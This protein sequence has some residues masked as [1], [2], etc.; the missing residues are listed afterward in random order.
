MH[1]NSEGHMRQMLI[2]GE[3]AGKHI[4]D[5]SMQFQH[6]FVQLLSKRHGTDRVKAINVYQE[7]IQDKNHLHM[8]A[9]G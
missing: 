7:F 2:V 4:S 9:T 3:N 8:N 5:Y 1:A 6:D